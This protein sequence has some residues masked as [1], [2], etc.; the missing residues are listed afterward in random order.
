MK[1]K[2][3]LMALMLMA[4]VPFFAH[5]QNMYVQTKGENRYE[6]DWPKGK[7]VLYSHKDGLV[8]GEFYKGKPNGVCVCYKPNGE[9]YWGN[10]KKGK[11]T[12][13]G[14]IYRDNGIVISGDYRKGT[15]HGVDTLYRKNGTVL[16]GKFKNGRL[17]DKIMDSSKDAV[18]K[19]PGMKPS[20]P[21]VDLKNRHEDF[22]KELELKWEERNLNLRRRAGF[23]EPQFQG[24]NLSDFTYWVN[25]QVRNPSMEVA[26]DRIR[27]V[28]V[29]FVVAKDGSIRDAHA[30][31]GSDPRLNEEAVR[32]VSRSPKWKPGEQNGEKKSIKL[33]VPVVFEY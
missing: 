28:V 25:S 21:R 22:L 18:G 19:H 3:I 10:F 24:G 13:K 6:G 9:V 33:T 5:G 20:Y 27:T 14:R 4:S 17:K 29:E 31:F 8:L 2:S 16:I 30:L 1:T 26:S 23:I 32:I 11:A 15:Y 7:G 12:G